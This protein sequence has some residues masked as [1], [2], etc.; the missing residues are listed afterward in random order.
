MGEIKSMFFWRAVL[1]EFIGTTA[2]LYLI[3]GVTVTWNKAIPVT[4]TRISLTFGFSIAGLVHIF[5]SSSGGHLNP[6]V[7]IG[8]FIGRRISFLRTVL[9]VIAQCAGSKY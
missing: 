5:G 2:F 3:C 7:S 9:Y 8:L 4:I 1:A 6:A